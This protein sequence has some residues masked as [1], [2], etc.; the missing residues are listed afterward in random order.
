MEIVVPGA[1]RLEQVR[2][3]VHEDVLMCSDRAG[4]SPGRGEDP[5]QAAAAVG[6]EVD[7]GPAL[8]GDVVAVRRLQAEHADERLLKVP[9]RVVVTRRGNSYWLVRGGPTRSIIDACAGGI[10][11]GG[12]GGGW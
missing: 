4:S 7:G 5:Q 8:G 11:T 2:V 10:Y 12:S 3:E 9:A 1:V 6:V